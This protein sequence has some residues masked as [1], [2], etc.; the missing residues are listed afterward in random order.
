M[1]SCQ[2]N[3]LPFFNK[4]T[5]QHQQRFDR[6][7]Y[8]AQFMNLRS[9]EAGTGENGRDIVLYTVPFPSQTMT[10]A[11][12]PRCVMKTGC[13]DDEMPLTTSLAF[14]LRSEIGIIFGV[15]DIGCTSYDTSN[16]TTNVPCRQEFRLGL[17]SANAANQPRR[18]L[19]R[20][21]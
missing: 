19:R 3:V 4:S 9:T 7:Q 13:L 18:F 14:C 1:T 20:L 5:T 15:I 12:R 8:S 10:A 2:V 16:S 17:L 21:N 11:A 6:T